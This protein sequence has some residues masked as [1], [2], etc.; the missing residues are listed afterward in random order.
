MERHFHRRSHQEL[1][2]RLDG[3]VPGEGPG[4]TVPT[5]FPSID[6]ML[7][8]GL[9]DQDLVI[10]GGDVGSGKSSLALAIAIR[11]A[12]AGHEVRFLS[13][14]M[15]EDRLVERALA[16][17]SRLTIEQLRSGKLDEGERARVGA[18]ALRLDEIPLTVTPIRGRAFDD[19][20]EGVLASRPALLVVDY[21]QLLPAPIPQSSPIEETAAALRALKSLAMTEQVAC[22]VTSQLAEFDPERD[23]PR[24]RLA[25]YGTLGSIKQHADVVLSIFREEM[26][27]P[28]TGIDGATELL[29]AKN[30]NGATGFVDLYFYRQWLRFEDMLDPE[31]PSRPRP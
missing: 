15:H 4:D 2:R 20:F 24:P 11:A 5:N 17:E 13:G 30:R 25:D 6:R 27:G 10:L 21:L 22:L 14:E 16:I 28:R 3:I 18:T 1:T 9:R 7:G 12:S 29:V 31:E 26:Y 8:G 19:V 23:D